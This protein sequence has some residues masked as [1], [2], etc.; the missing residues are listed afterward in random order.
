MP[1]GGRFFL[2]LF[3]LTLG[4]LK[5]ITSEFLWKWGVGGRGR[6]GYLVLSLIHLGIFG[7]P[8][9]RIR[10]LKEV[11]GINPALMLLNRTLGYT[12]Q[13]MWIQRGSDL[14]LDSPYQVKTGHGRGEDRSL[15]G[16]V[17][18]TP[19]A[20]PKAKLKPKNWAQTACCKASAS[21]CWLSTCRGSDYTFR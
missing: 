2:F 12:A 15:C 10:T 14:K 6:T 9:G 17:G 13:N 21:G 3:H 1:P 5:I 20:T 7:F 19:C 8:F 16:G 11:F 4:S 18:G